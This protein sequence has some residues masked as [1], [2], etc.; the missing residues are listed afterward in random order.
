MLSRIAA[1]NSC[2]I[3]NSSFFSLANKSYRVTKKLE[4]GTFRVEKFFFFFF[5]TAR[6]LETPYRKFHRLLNTN[7]FLSL[8]LNDV[9]CVLI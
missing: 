4:S 9:D 7:T 1:I 5:Y 8:V 3:T 6:R 2:S